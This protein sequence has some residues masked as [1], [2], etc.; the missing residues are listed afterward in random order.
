MLGDCDIV[1]RQI[2]EAG[3]KVLRGESVQLIMNQS[4]AAAVNGA[5]AIPDLC[6]MSVRRAINRLTAEKLDVAVVGS[7]IVVHHY[8]GANEFAL[9][10]TKVTLICEPKPL[11]SAQLY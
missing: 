5:I 1:Y 11:A 4:N 3:K 6:G 10:G 2:P 8:P 9:P 7:G